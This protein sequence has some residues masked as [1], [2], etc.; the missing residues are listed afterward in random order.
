ME[1][2]NTLFDHFI[3]LILEEH[4]KVDQINAILKEM[5]KELI[6][7]QNENYQIYGVYQYRIADECINALNFLTESQISRY[8]NQLNTFRN[9][10]EGYYQQLEIT[11]QSGLT[12]EQNNE[13]EYQLQRYQK[14]K[15]QGSSKIIALSHQIKSISNVLLNKN[16]KEV[17]KMSGQVAKNASN[18]KQTL[19]SFSKASASKFNIIVTLGIAA[20][21]TCKVYYDYRKMLEC[22]C[23]EAQKRDVLLGFQQQLKALGARTICS[24]GIT[25]GTITLGAAIGSF[26]PIIG[27]FAGGVLGALVGG[28]CSYFV[29]KNVID[30]IFLVQNDDLT[31]YEKLIGLENFRSV[32]N[33]IDYTKEEFDFKYKKCLLNDHPDKQPTESLK[34]IARQKVFKI[35]LAKQ[36]IYQQ[37][38]WS[39]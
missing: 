39:Q 22:C 7:V 9:L 11:V 28:I 35:Q 26:F 1:K 3:S 32:N 16:I 8:Q 5:D 23:N 29:E 14:L 4:Q 36:M 15:S 2:I 34:A 17:L 6:L 20:A 25:T 18:L 27:T 21:E 33:G 12:S 19:L 10:F 38:G 37:R 31:E 13:I 24:A 30:P